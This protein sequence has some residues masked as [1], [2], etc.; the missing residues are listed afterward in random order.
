[1]TKLKCSICGKKI[2]KMMLQIHTCR[3]EKIFCSEHKH[4]HECTYDY[5]QHIQ[6]QVK[7][8]SSKIDKI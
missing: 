3:C 8:K 2:P 6:Q 4:S 5:K 1:M 7:I